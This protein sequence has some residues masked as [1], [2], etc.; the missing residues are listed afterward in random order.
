MELWWLVFIVMMMGLRI[1]IK[2]CFSLYLWGY[3]YS[4]EM[5]QEEWTYMWMVSPHELRSQTGWHSLNTAFYRSLIPDLRCYIP[6]CFML[7]LLCFLTVMDCTAGHTFPSF[8]H[9]H[10][11]ILSQQQSRSYK[12]SDWPGS[13][14]PHVRV[15]KMLCE[16]LSTT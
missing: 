15:K 12:V 5:E 13:L 8:S 11:G 3:I 4:C 10:Q 7:L 1:T 16:Y 6:R 2:M 14:C 9:F